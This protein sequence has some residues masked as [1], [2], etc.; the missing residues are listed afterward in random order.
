MKNFNDSLF[1]QIKEISCKY[2]ELYG[3][4]GWEHTERVVELCRYFGEKLDVDISVLLTAALLHDIGRGNTNHAEKSAEMAE[5]ILRELG[6][7]E[8]EILKI[9]DV[10]ITHSWTATKK[11]NSMEAKILSDSD[12]LDAIGAIGIYRAAM[13]N[14]EQ[15]HSFHTFIDHFHE[16][17]LKIKDYLFIDEAKKIANDRHT[18]LICYL[19]EF[20][21]EL[22]IS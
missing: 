9:K 21:R 22:N 2:Q 3:C 6:Y 10:I 20:K 1:K 14:C 4:H 17:L 19:Q 8:N 15:G 13:F 7:K 5:P 11:A 18:F 16:K 12:K